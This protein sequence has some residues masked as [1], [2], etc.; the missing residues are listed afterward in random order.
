MQNQNKKSHHYGVC[1]FSLYLH[2]FSPGTSF[3][4]SMY[5]RLIGESELSIGMNVSVCGCLSIS[6]PA[7]N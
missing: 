2:G 6:D 1:M 3:P 5:V 7:M 4:N